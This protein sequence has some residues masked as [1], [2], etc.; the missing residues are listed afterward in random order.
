MVIPARTSSEPPPDPRSVYNRGVD[1]LE[2]GDL[3]QAE[4]QLARARR[5]AGDDEKLRQYATY[6]LGF[7]A[8][9]RAGRMEGE[10]PEEALQSL[11]QAAD[12][13]RD[14]AKVAR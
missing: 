9:Q 11:Y 2:A 10:A 12:W 6:D 8:A 14:A 1:A 5:S 13:F 7:A 4:R 3:E